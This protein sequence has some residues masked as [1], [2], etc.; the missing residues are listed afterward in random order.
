MVRA[1]NVLQDC[2]LAAVAHVVVLQRNSLAGG[3]A[4]AVGVVVVPDHRVHRR[5]GLFGGLDPDVAVARQ[6]GTRR[7]EL[8]DDDVLFQT[9]AA[10]RTWRGSPRR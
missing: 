5:L 1:L 7:D 6:A 8:S 10:S 3:A 4:E 2:G 9:R